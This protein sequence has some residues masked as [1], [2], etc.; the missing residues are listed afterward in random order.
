MVYR[1]MHF[2]CTVSSDLTEI[3]WAKFYYSHLPNEEVEAYR[4][5]SIISKDKE[6]V[7]SK[8]RIQIKMVRF[9]SSQKN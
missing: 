5:S 8:I 6:R 3:K 2:K 1:A 7:N 4:N 9:Q